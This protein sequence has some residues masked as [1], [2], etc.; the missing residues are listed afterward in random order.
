MAKL[1]NSKDLI[2]RGDVYDALMQRATPLVGGGIASFVVDYPQA[3]DSVQAVDAR[4][5][6]RGEWLVQDES[7][8][9]GHYSQDIQVNRVSLKCS[10]CGHRITRRDFRQVR[11]YC[12]NCG[13]DMR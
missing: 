9:R 3:V 1:N 7:F 10:N 6:V 2:Y 12:P 13:A 11:R 8:W 4:P 5:V